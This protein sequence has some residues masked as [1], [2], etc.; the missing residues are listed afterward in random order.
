VTPD[1]RGSGKGG[2]VA[3]RVT[4]VTGGAQGIGRAAVELFAREG[5]QV[6]FVDLAKDEGRALQSELR[7]QGSTVRFIDGDASNADDVQRVVAET[8][9]V[10]GRIDILFNNAGYN[11]HRQLTELDEADWRRLLDVNL[12]SVLLFTK[13]VLP[14]MI[15]QGGGS[16]VNNASSLG[17]IGFPKVPA[18]SASKGA[19]ISLTRQLAVD[20]AKHNIRVN[21]ICPGPTLTPRLKRDMDSGALAPEV[22]E[23]MIRDVLVGRLARP[24]EVAAAVLFLASEEASFITGTAL[25]VDGGQMAH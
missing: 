25:A 10:R 14:Q 18:Y 17:L 5:A 7:G 13:V 16:V 21:C 3:G 15:T 11:I 8:M 1:T 22:V 6:V 24:E 19:I 23:R 4:L 20:Y 12:G 9:R 2:R